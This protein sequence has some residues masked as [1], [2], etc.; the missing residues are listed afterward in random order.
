[1]LYELFKTNW[2]SML[3][4]AFFLLPSFHLLL[5]QKPYKKLGKFQPT[6]TPSRHEDSTSKLKPLL[7]ICLKGSQSI[8]D[9]PQAVKHEL[10]IL[11]AP[12]DDDDLTNKILMALVMIIKNL[13]QL[14]KLRILRSSLT[15]SMK[16]SWILKFLL[17][18]Q[19][20]NFHTS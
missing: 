8:K 1:M 16:N 7:K 11:R 19:K 12:I 13:C 3:W 4:L 9:F 17:K 5:E 2:F 10:V 6:H 15:N 18:V 20:L 14:F